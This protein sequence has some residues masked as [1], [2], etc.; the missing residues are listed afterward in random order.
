VRLVEQRGELA[1][2]RAGFGD[3]CDLRTAFDDRN[4]TAFENQKPPGFRAFGEHRLARAITRK[5]KRGEPLSPNL[6][7]VNK[8]H[9][10]APLGR[11]DCGP[12]EPREHYYERPQTGNVGRRPQ[13]H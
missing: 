1:E 12:C 10:N 5:R 11:F 4:R 3:C 9:V 13:A 8:P 7:I 2:H 6:R